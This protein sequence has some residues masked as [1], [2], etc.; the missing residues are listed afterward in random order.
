MHAISYLFPK[1]KLNISIKFICSMYVLS[2]LQGVKKL[3]YFMLHLNLF[4]AKFKN[5]KV[6]LLRKT[7][8]IVITSTP[9]YNTNFTVT[10]SKTE[11]TI[12]KLNRGEKFSAPR[13]ISHPVSSLGHLTRAKLSSF[14]SRPSP[15]TQN[16]RKWYGW[17]VSLAKS[18]WVPH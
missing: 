7:E 17:C 3:C 1:C 11:H 10:K 18:S 16:V 13:H 14:A 6:S 2:T 9:Y 8:F 4:P 5:I 15:F 12:H